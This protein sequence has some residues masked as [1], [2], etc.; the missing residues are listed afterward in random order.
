MS[1]TCYI[2][3]YNFQTN[4]YI[5]KP[6]LTIINYTLLLCK[7]DLSDLQSHKKELK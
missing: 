1:F 2:C 7:Y 5:I 4:L 6:F 3:F